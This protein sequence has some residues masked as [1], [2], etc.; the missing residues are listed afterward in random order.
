MN[1]R[2]ELIKQKHQFKLGLISILVEK[3]LL[4]G[5]FAFVAFLASK[6]IESYKDNLA[7]KR[8]FLEHR[9]LGLQKVN[10]AYTKLADYCYLRG[11]QK[12]ELTEPQKAEHTKALNEFIAETKQWSFLFPDNF[13][14]QLQYHVWLH[15]AVVTEAT[16]ITRDNYPFILAICDNFAQMTREALWQETLGRE[17]ISPSQ[18]TFQFHQWKLEDMGVKT[19]SDFF[20]ANF[21]KWRS[22]SIKPSTAPQLKGS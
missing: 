10:A 20:N 22:E 2:G 19:G 5:V 14:K 13:S 6:A 8:F 4:A 12:N 9:L 16:P 3:L 11:A 21:E 15:D 17:I 18:Q 1:L 7:E